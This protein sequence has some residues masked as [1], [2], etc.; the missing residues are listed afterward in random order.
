[1]CTCLPLRRAADLLN[2]RVQLLVD[3]V[4]AGHVEH[5]AHGSHIQITDNGLNELRWRIAC[6]LAAEAA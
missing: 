2:V 1:M 6:A 4:E 3:L 5:H